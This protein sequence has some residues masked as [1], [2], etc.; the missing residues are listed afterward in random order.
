M[1]EPLAIAA[2]SWNSELV[3]DAAGAPV[4]ASSVAPVPVRVS[5]LVAESVQLTAVF[6]FNDTAPVPV[7]KVP[8]PVMPKL[9]LICV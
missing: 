3:A 4:A 9:P 7:L 1:A 5:V 6:P 2:P 8:V